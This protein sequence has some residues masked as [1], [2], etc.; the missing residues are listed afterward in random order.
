M[1][2]A[3]Y[4]SFFIHPV[5]N[6]PARS[7]SD[8]GTKHLYSANVQ[9]RIFHYQHDR[10]DADPQELAF[11]VFYLIRMESLVYFRDQAILHQLLLQPPIHKH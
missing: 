9:Y 8:T 3:L 7:P 11:G 2:H 6:V 4:F 1:L 10:R 5:E